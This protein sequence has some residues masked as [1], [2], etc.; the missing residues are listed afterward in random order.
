M[1]MNSFSS[2]L[3]L[4]LMIGG[5]CGEIFSEGG[6]GEY[7]SDGTED[8]RLSRRANSSNVQLQTL[9]DKFETRDFRSFSTVCTKK[10][11]VNED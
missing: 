2:F 4:I 3:A 9:S 8:L 10:E 11:R 5:K 1:I 7:H 6:R